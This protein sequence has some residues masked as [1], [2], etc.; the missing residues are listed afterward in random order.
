[1]RGTASQVDALIA[2]GAW[3]SP[4]S[5]DA[6]WGQAAQLGI[7]AQTTD[8]DYGSGP[9]RFQERTLGVRSV[10]HDPQGFSRR[11]RPFGEPQY[12]GGGQ[13]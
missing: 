5:R 11:F 1:V 13:L 3:S 8:D 10:G 6:S 12:L 2:V 9:Q 7:F 4:A